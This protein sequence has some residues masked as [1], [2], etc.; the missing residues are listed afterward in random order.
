MPDQMTQEEAKPQWTIQEP[1][2]GMMPNGMMLNGIMPSGSSQTVSQ[3]TGEPL[4]F[5]QVRERVQGDDRGKWDI[6]LPR[7][8]VLM[9]NGNLLFPDCKLYECEDGL[10]PLPWATAQ[11]CQRLNIPTGYFK[12]CPAHMQDTQFNFWNGRSR[13]D[14]RSSPAMLEAPPADS[15]PEEN[16]YCHPEEFEESNGYHPSAEN[17]GFYHGE[18]E[19]YQNG[20]Q[21]GPRNGHQFKNGIYAG[22]EKSDYWLLR[23]KGESLRAVLTD[24]YTPLDNR[25]LIEALQKTLPSHFE[26]QWLALNEESF[27]LRLIDPTLSRE[28]LAGDP[29]MAG[30]HISN[31]ECGRR[32]AVVDSTVFRKVCANGMIRLIRGKNIL[33]QR[34]VAVSPPHFVAL[35]KQSLSIGL[36]TASDFMEQM[37][38]ATK[39]SVRDVEAEMKS[40]AQHWHLSQS[41]VGQVQASLKLER[42]D[43]QETVFGLVNAVT[44]AAQ[45]LDA[46]ARYEME[47]VAGKLLERKSMQSL[48]GGGRNRSVRVPETLPSDGATPGE[49]DVSEAIE[50]AEVLFEAQV[51]A[52][53]PGSASAVEGEAVES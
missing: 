47:V 21:R 20:W 10:T 36:A 13:S 32:A 22:A 42:A 19:E 50:A 34:H 44:Q 33:C 14:L 43:Q 5:E 23:A 40:L 51:V 24:R 15:Y 8:E 37:E 39:E 4:S 30:L 38:W 28:V 18:P 25:T 41:F 26:V 6:V 35:L 2:M 7:S 53:S 9:R 16:G 12:R 11:I 31:S 46:E 45:T 1:A 29:I 48:R 27:H 3:V 49:S 52:T 17:D